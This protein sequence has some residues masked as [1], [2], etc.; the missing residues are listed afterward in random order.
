MLYNLVDI[1]I[2]FIPPISLKDIHNYYLN[3][4]DLFWY[5]KKVK[6]NFGVMRKQETQNG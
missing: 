4:H 2:I 1:W 3:I 5:V 6:L